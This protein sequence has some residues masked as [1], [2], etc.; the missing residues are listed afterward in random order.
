MKE[1]ILNALEKRDKDI[2]LFIWKGKKEEVNGRKVQKEI[3]MVDCTVE[4]LNDFLCHCDSMLYNT[5]PN[6]PGRYTLLNIISEQRNKCNTELFIRWLDKVKETPKYVFI[7]ILNEFLKNNPQ[8]DPK[9]NTISTAL[10]GCPK[11]FGNLPISTVIEGCLD[12]LGMFNRQHIT[13]SFIL[14]HGIWF[15]PEELKEMAQKGVEDKL[16]Y[17]GSTLGLNDYSS[18]KINPKGLSLTQLQAMIS[19]RNK[20]YS[21]LSTTQLETLRNRIL[22]SLENEVKFH[23]KQWE[24]RIK[25]INLVL[26]SKNSK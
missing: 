12:S 23:I 16:K 3:K 22:F 8:V 21:E 20:K 13:L 9:T 19:L 1:Q 18:L 11:E 17:A 4:E 24:T 14:K 7:S 6:N 25:Q 2:N 10:G 5:N 26:E 15:S